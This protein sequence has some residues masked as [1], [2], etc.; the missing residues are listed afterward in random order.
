MS[1]A[2]RSD[3]RLLIIGAGPTGLTA[4]IKA[5]QAGFQP[6]LV[7]RASGPT[8]ESRA[9]GVNQASLQLL[10]DTGTADAIM[11][12]GIPVKTAYFFNGE[13][14]L[15]QLKLPQPK[16][17]QPALVALPQSETEHILI[18]AL[19]KLGHAPQWNTQVEQVEQ[20]ASK[21]RAILASGEVLVGDWMLGADGS[22]SGVRRSLGLDFEGRKYPDSW[23]LVDA[24]IDWPFSDAEIAVYFGK[25]GAVLFLVTLGQDRF[26]II[27]N[28]PDAERQLHER[29]SVREIILSDTFTVS[30]RQANPFGKGRIWIAGDAG[31]VHSPVGGMGMNLGIEDAVDFVETL[32]SRHDPAAFSGYNQRRIKAAKRVLSFTDIG[33]KFVSSKGT[34]APVLRNLGVRTIASI[35]LIRDS[36]AQRFLS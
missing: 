4:A 2:T 25:A 7:D 12:H 21:V 13:K 22:R 32:K 28:R 36:I 14:P 3:D 18:E 6:I 19:A 23:S 1:G 16:N 17:D 30:L 26:R 15:A 24:K 33:Y 31:H 10:Q 35:G 29:F 8:I 9:V 27:S 20:S 5:A 11:S 34:V